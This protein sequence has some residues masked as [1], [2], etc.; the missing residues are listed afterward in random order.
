MAVG[1]TAGLWSLWVITSWFSRY[2]IFSHRIL[3]IVTSVLLVCLA[4]GYMYT[5]FHGRL[6]KDF[7]GQAGASVSDQ[8][9]HLFWSSIQLIKDVPITGG[10]LDSFPGLYSSYILIDP[11]Y[12]LPY[13]HN[14]YLD[15]SLYQGI[16]GGIMLCCII[17]GSIILLVLQ[18]VPTPHS[19]LRYAI[20]SG[21][22]IISIHGLL[23]NIIYSTM[24]TTLLFFLPGMAVG[25]ITS[26]NSQPE[27]ILWRKSQVRSVVAPVF[28]TLGMILIGL[29]SF[30]RPLLSA[31]YTD[32]GSVEMAKVELSDFPTGIWDEG[33]HADLLSPAESLFN[34]ALIYEPTNPRAN[35]RL[36]L[37]AMLKRDF[38]TAVNHLEIAHRGDTY[39]RGMLKALGFSYLWNGQIEAA[40]PLLSLIPESDYEVGNYTYWWSELDRPDLVAY[41]EQYLEMV[42]S[43]QK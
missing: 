36:G 32:L 39:H 37:I 3:F 2:K 5:S 17:L 16:L 18:S 6:N 7:I 42:G 1:I 43:R 15:V 21:L 12:I 40:L 11:N 20:L 19:L 23:D 35:Y 25:L 4:F 33:Q 29:I 24:S 30:R 34:R 38:P 22:V 10:G 13:S 28:I 26:T 9:A 14:L 31:W 41:A 8:R 27:R